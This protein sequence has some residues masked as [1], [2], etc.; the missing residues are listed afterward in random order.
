[1]KHS[2][3]IIVL[4]FLV[5]YS[6]HAQDD[7]SYNLRQSLREMIQLEEQYSERKESAIANKLILLYKTISEDHADGSDYYT[8]CRSRMLVELRRYDEA[9]ALLDTL[10][11][12][13]KELYKERV[14][15]MKA[16]CDNDTDSFNRHLNSIL[17]YLDV[18]TSK[19]LDIEDSIMR[20]PIGVGLSVDFDMNVCTLFE[21]RHC[22]YSISVGK[23]EAC[24][25]LIDHAQKKNWDLGQL[26]W[27]LK[28]INEFNYMSLTWW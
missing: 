1:M 15:L 8:L 20:I 16:S 14:S 19:Y 17:D 9:I 25:K 6:M 4:L 24:R 2:K 3:R 26:N 10:V 5:P 11:D 27:L 7:T 23:E 21:L 13:D 18:Q 12:K 28:T 22:Y